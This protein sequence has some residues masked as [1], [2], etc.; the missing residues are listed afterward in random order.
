M[1]ED[2]VAKADL[3]IDEWI[4]AR[5]D[6]LLNNRTDHWSMELKQKFRSAA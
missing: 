4:K 1:T 2:Q 5:D 6:D 3:L